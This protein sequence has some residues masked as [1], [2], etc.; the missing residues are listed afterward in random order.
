MTGNLL[1]RRP[2]FPPSLTMAASR[3]IPH[4]PLTKIVYHPSMHKPVQ[5]LCRLYQDYSNRNLPT[6]WN[7][8]KENMPGEFYRQAL[9][10]FSTFELIARL[11]LCV[12]TDKKDKIPVLRGLVLLGRAP[13]FC[14]DDLMNAGTAGWPSIGKLINT[15]DNIEMPGECSEGRRD[16]HYTRGSD[17]AKRFALVGMALIARPTATARY[18]C[19]RC[20]I[21]KRKC[22]KQRP[23]CGRCKNGAQV[24][25]IR[26]RAARH[27]KSL[28]EDDETNAPTPRF[29]LLCMALIARPTR[30]NRQSTTCRPCASRKRKCDKQRPTC[31]PCEKG[32]LVCIWTE[33][34][35]RQMA[36]G[37]CKSMIE[38]DQTSSVIGRGSANANLSGQASHYFDH[39]HTAS[40]L[41]DP[42]HIDQ[43]AIQWD[44]PDDQGTS[45]ISWPFGVIPKFFGVD[46]K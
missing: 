17:L 40:H 25:H 34:K 24:C 5:E 6:V 32:A 26:Q 7:V 1:N 20:A 18:A 3:A 15:K 33:P 13:V 4:Y 43:T 42:S 31:G 46:L 9:S 30:R 22:D 28:N 21:T 12:K 27:R 39:W 35:G 45:G 10:D 11:H 16:A 37:Q 14:D 44:W 36:A 23:T 29:S 38:D 2:S 19:E 8:E 41:N